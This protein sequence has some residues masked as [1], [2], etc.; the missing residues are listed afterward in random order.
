MLNPQR[1][2]HRPAGT[3]FVR[4]RGAEQGHHAV[5]RVLVDRAL[6]T[7]HLGCNALEAAIDHVMDHFRIELLGE[8][9]EAGHVGKEDG[10][11]LA[12]AFER[13]A[14]GEDFLD[15]VWG[16]VGTRRRCP[17]GPQDRGGRS[18]RG[19]G[20]GWLGL[21]GPHQTPAVFIHNLGMG[22]E[23]LFLQV[24]QRRLIEAKLPFERAIRDPLPAPEQ[25]HDL[26]QHRVK[27]H[28]SSLLTTC[29]RSD[30]VAIV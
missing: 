23:E 27:V 25:L 20:W 11:L 12:F 30:T 3:I 4:Q 29:F 10:H 17:R 5:T 26:V 8:R 19:G 24:F 28:P 1:G 14:R 7:V 21:S 22:K 2:V 9:G 13:A 16:C 18:R 15:Q 6:E